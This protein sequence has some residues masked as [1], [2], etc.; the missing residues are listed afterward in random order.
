[1]VSSPDSEC[2]FGIKEAKRFPKIVCEKVETW[3]HVAVS[4]VRILIAGHW[5][6]KSF[7]I[8]KVN[9]R[10][11]SPVS[12]IQ[13]RAVTVCKKIE[14]SVTGGFSF[15]FSAIGSRLLCSPG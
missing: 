4:S 7:S 11:I 9:S 14:K 15:S 3:T 12:K 5:R 10:T 1:M 13:S 6:Q 2:S 8:S